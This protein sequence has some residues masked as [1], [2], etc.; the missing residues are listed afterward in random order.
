MQ[1]VQSK[2]RLSIDERF[3]NRTKARRN[4]IRQCLQLS[5]IENKDENKDEAMQ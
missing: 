3:N 2:S 1:N 5:P 4:L